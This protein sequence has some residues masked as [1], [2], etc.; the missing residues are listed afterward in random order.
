M[1]EGP[2][3]PLGMSASDIPVRKVFDVGLTQVKMLRPL[4]FWGPSQ[5]PHTARFFMAPLGG[6]QNKPS[7]PRYGSPNVD[8]KDG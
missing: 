1:T 6:T 2:R 4:I 3:V 8:F 5:V 7:T